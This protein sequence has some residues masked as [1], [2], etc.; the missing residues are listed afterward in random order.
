MYVM[1]QIL[2]SCFSIKEFNGSD[3]VI[4]NLVS[5][6]LE[7]GQK[8]NSKRD[9]CAK[10]LCKIVKNHLNFNKN[11]RDEVLSSIKP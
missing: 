6:V 1:L 11:G 2:S 3:I 7:I 8:F 10:I 5:L 4:E 9:I